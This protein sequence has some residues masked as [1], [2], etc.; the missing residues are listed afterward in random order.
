V[1]TSNPLQEALAP[2]LKPVESMIGA[3]PA[4][5][6]GTDSVELECIIFTRHLLGVRPDRTVVETYKAALTAVPALQP[7]SAWDRSLLAMARRG[8]AGARCADAFA[9]LFART[10]V[11]RNRL[12]ILLAILE[13]R[14]PYS[15]TIDRALGG[16]GV[17]VMTRVALRGVWSLAW[18]VAGTVLLVPVRI[19]L[20]LRGEPAR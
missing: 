6:T 11:L 8:V 20:M 1:A 15:D 17:L 14:A 13:T 3:T 4:I 18:L 12:V 9:A 2:G 7:S 10:S 19:A 16:P 5:G